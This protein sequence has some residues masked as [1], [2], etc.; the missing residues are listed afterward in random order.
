MIGYVFQRPA[1]NLMPH[2]SVREHLEVAAKLRDR[3]DERADELLEVLGMSHRRNHL[4]TQLSGGEQQR[5]AFAR[6][7][8]GDPALVVA[9]E[10]TAELDSRS[11]VSLLQAVRHL[12]ESGSTFVVAT[13]DPAVVASSDA[14]LALRHGAMEFDTRQ[15]RSLA[16]IDDSGR[17]QLPPEAV[18]H[19]P[20]RR[21]VLRHVG[22]GRVEITPP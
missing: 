10:P 21:A 20:G 11:T 7:V 9:D 3:S 22:E 17:I 14:T 2:V 12:A 13:H 15:A 4:P 18:K 19:Y 1:E 8:I 16:V 6:A 5:A